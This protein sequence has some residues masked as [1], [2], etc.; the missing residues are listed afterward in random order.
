MDGK[1]ETGG[2]ED[3]SSTIDTTYGLRE[4]DKLILLKH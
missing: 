4:P 3:I 1:M 2:E